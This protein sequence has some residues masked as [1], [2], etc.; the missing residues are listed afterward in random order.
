MVEKKPK[1]V[2]GATSELELCYEDITRETI[3]SGKR[4]LGQE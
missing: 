3:S 1:L 2:E 4:D